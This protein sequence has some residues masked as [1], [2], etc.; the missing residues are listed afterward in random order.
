[1][2]GYWTQFATTGNPNKPG[3]PSWDA[4]DRRADQALQLGKDIKMI[5][6][7]RAQRFSVFERILNA[8]L[9]GR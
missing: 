3:L 5:A 8:R 1:M 2:T 9:A 7:P 4:Y 6:V